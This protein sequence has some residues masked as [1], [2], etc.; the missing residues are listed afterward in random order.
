MVRAEKSEVEHDRRNIIEQTR[1][2][3]PLDPS[4][5]IVIDLTMIQERHKTP[6]KTRSH[7]GTPGANESQAAEVS[8]ASPKPI[9]DENRVSPDRKEL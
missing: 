8:D 6:E 7:R 4:E 3:P 5:T 9:I 2:S 1:V